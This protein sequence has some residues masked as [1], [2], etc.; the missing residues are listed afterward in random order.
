MTDEAALVRQSER[1][2]ESFQVDKTGHDK[3]RPNGNGQYEGRI[4]LF[5]D[6]MRRESHC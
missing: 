3:T 2:S 1:N 5:R 4:I 6:C